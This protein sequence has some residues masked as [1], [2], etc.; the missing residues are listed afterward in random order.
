M[1]SIGVSVASAVILVSTAG[2]ARA[3][4]TYDHVVVVMF[5]NTD[6]AAAMTQP[7][8]A[9]FATANSADVGVNASPVSSG[10]HE[11]GAYPS[12]PNY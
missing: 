4:T 7:D 9:A 10:Y 8:F 1:R 12:L 11:F 2:V 6:R 3:Q 5:E